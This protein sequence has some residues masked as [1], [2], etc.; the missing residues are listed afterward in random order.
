LTAQVAA[1]I[2]TTFN[3]H[4]NAT[5]KQAAIVVPAPARHR[6][7]ADRRGALG[8]QTAARLCRD[9][10]GGRA[11]AP[12]VSS[13]TTMAVSVLPSGRK[14]FGVIQVE[15]RARGGLTSRWRHEASGRA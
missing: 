11:A 6:P 3:R 5:T 10:R 13:R 14:P 4:A 12:S 9:K 15:E 7:T 8:S 1:C 2:A